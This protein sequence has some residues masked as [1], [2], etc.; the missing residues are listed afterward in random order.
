MA[1]DAGSHGD[2]KES[3]CETENQLTEMG[4][5]KNQI[6]QDMVFIGK[7]KRLWEAY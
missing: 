7:G 4:V 5:D 1:Q 6:V 3:R 2:H